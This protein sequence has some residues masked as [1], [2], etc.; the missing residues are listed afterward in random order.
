VD[1][2]DFFF[3][4]ATS[5]P[6]VGSSTENNLPAMADHGER[7]RLVILGGAGVGK[8]CIVKR[9]LLATFCD[10]YKST[11]EDLYYREYDLGS[12]TLKV[13]QFHCRILHSI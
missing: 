2:G 8:S 12:V 1:T 11:V 4:S 10:R 7:I 9:F 5:S 6:K 13:S 3:A